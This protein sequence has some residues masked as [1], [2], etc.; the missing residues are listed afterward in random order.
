MYRITGGLLYDQVW[1]MGSQESDECDGHGN[2]NQPS[3]DGH[4][5]QSSSESGFP[6]SGWRLRPLL[7]CL[8][9]LVDNCQ[10]NEV[11]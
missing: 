4:K 10:V 11:R 1:R 3:S 2:K 5:N 7:S 8:E 9:S 6:V